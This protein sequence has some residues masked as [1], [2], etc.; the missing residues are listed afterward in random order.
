[1]NVFQMQMHFRPH[2]KLSNQFFSLKF[3]ASIVYI[4]VYLL[5]F[6]SFLAFAGVWDRS[7]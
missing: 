5:L 1:M 7:H 6:F 3:E 2:K 4:H